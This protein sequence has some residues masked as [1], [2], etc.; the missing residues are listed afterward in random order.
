MSTF[1][2]ADVIDGTLHGAQVFD[3]F[4]ILAI[5]CLRKSRDRYKPYLPAFA[6]LLM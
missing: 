6:C 3:V 5:E 2:L 4:K 1:L